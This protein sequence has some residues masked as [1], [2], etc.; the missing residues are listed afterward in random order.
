MTERVDNIAWVLTWEEMASVF[1]IQCDVSYRFVMGDKPLLCLGTF[2]LI[3]ACLGLLLWKNVEFCQG[4]LC[5]C[6][7]DHVI[8]VLDFVC[9]LYYIYW[10]AYVEPSLHTW[11]K[12]NLIMVYDL[13]TVLLNSVC[14]YFI[15]NFCVYAHQ[16]IWSVI[17]L[18]CVF[19]SVF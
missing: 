2:L 6:W 18:F 1:L 4:F 5:I 7:D 19:L 3:L 11:N 9:V 10:F 14:K 8:F 17:F 16:E 15:E 13:L 12:T